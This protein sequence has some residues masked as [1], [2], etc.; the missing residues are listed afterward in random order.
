VQG[1]R[2]KSSLLGS[3]VVVYDECDPN[4]E[5]ELVNH[6]DAIS[7]SKSEFEERRENV[8]ELRQAA[9]RYSKYI[10]PSLKNANSKHGR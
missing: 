1:S 7:K 2:E 9:K 10:W 6:F 8:Q 4:W 5:L 3:A